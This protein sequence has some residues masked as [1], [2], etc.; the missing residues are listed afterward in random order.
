MRN[1]YRASNEKNSNRV[2]RQWQ[3][4][5]KTSRIGNI[6]YCL[7]KCNEMTLYRISGAVRGRKLGE[8][9]AGVIDGNDT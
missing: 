9:T 3:E 5:S 1:I 4:K 2:K 6:I 8:T 7:E